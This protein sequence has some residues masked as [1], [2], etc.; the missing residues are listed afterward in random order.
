MIAETSTELGQAM[1]DRFD[2]IAKQEAHAMLEPMIQKVSREYLLVD[3][4]TAFK[5]LCMS[6]TFFD[7]NLKNLPQLKVIERRV[8]NTRKVYYDPNELKRAVLS[9]LE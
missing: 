7:D 5:I 2:G 4:K 6:R 9:V 3:R 8:P 1:T